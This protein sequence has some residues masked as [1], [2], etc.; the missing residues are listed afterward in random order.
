MRRRLNNRN[1]RKNSTVADRQGA[2]GERSSRGEVAAMLRK[3]RSTTR[4]WQL[5]PTAWNIIRPYWSSEDRWAAWG[6]LVVVV[7]LTL[8]M[9]HIN[10]LFSY[11]NNAFFSALAE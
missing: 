2:A 7:A 3:I 9:V 10:V 5:L 6:L 11:W 1:H 4:L 8:G